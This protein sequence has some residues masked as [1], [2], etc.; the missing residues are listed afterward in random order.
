MKSTIAY[1]PAF[2]LFA[3]YFI[4]FVLHS[5]YVKLSAKILHN[6]KVSWKAAF[7][8]ALVMTLATLIGKVIALVAGV[9][10]PVNIAFVLSFAVNLVF[11][12]W[13]FTGPAL[14]WQGAQLGWVRA[15][16]I[17]ALAF[18]FLMVTGI[19]FGSVFHAIS[20]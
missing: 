8:F 10:V 4:V 2:V 13:F 12:G 11:G 20:S 16:Q 18:V 14:A 6:S 19:V 17:S 3:F 15:M 7:V 1:F 5:A 9:T